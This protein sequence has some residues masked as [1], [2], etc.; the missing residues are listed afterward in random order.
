MNFQIEFTWWRALDRR[1][2]EVIKA[3]APDRNREWTTLGPFEDP[4]IIAVRPLVAADF[5]W[6]KVKKGAAMERYHPLK[7]QDLWKQFSN[8]R[9]WEQGIEFVEKYGPLTRQGL[10]GKGDVIER[11]NGEAAEMRH[12]IRGAVLSRLTARIV[13]GRLRIEPSNLLNAIWLQYAKAKSAGRANRCPQCDRIT[14]GPD[15]GRRRDAKFCS[16]ECK[17]KWHNDRRGRGS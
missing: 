5:S 16:K 3:T 8:I 6:I 2:Y 1:D 11:I 15:T 17:I 12:N 9:D 7:V 13:D 10:E 14:T 4:L